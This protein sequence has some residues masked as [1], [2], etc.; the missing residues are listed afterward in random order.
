M[1][2]KEKEKALKEAELLIEDAVEEASHPAIRSRIADWYVS[3][4][5][6]EPGYD[7]VDVVVVG[8]FNTPDSFT[9]E[10]SSDSNDP[11]TRTLACARIS[12]IDELVK[13]LEALG[14]VAFEWGDE[15]SRCCECGRIVRTCSDG[16]GWTAYYV[17]LL[18]ADLYCI[19]C[20]KKDESLVQDVIEELKNESTKAVSK[21]WGLD[22]NK[23]GFVKV[24]VPSFETGFHEH[25]DDDPRVV[26]KYLCK[27]G[28]DVL[29]SVVSTGQFDVDW[30][31]WVSRGGEPVSPE[32]LEKLKAGLSDRK[33]VE[34]FSPSEAAKRALKGEH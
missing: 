12:P 33:N 32:E 28:Y 15:W 18:G 14:E 29:F 22:L 34:G 2:E 7:A 9:R 5:Y 20:V 31:V 10:D 19:G 3:P 6:A 24:G 4:G 17:I 8:N 23:Y 11:V 16:H 30:E 13:Q 25:Q 1:T 21:N 26:L 27:E